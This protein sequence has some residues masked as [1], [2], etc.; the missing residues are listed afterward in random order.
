[1]PEDANKGLKGYG[2]GFV[3]L[4]QNP[5]NKVQAGLKLSMD[6]RLE[7]K[8]TAKPLLQYF[9]SLNYRHV[10]PPPSFSVFFL[11]I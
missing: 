5:H 10:P 11:F 1:M 4:R 7:L 6:P 2:S 9:K 3:V 8:D